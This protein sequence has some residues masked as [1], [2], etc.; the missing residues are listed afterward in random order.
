[1]LLALRDIGWRSV[2]A[3][4]V[5][6]G[7]SDKIDFRSFAPYS[8]R[9]LARAAAVRKMWSSSSRGNPADDGM[10]PKEPIGYW[11]EP[12]MS[13]LQRAPEG[14]ADS[15]SEPEEEQAATPWTPSFQESAM[16]ST[17]VGGGFWATLLLRSV[18]CARTSTAPRITSF[19]NVLDANSSGKP[20]YAIPI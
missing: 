18:P 2:S 12:I 8:V 5:G 10:D 20:S 15:D 14:P 7:L 17:I 6:T 16:L 19:G 1:M 4:V 9:E 13:V 11:I 3:I